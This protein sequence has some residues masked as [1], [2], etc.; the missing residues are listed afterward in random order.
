V[1]KLDDRT[2]ADMPNPS[3][4][5]RRS[6]DL[7][8]TV[9]LPRT[10]AL[11]LAFALLCAGAAAPAYAQAPACTPTHT[12]AQLQGD[13]TSSPFNF[14]LATTTGVVTARWT[15]SEPKGFFVQMAA[16]DG[17]AT[18]SDA[19]FVT[20]GLS[21]PPLEAMPGHEVCVEGMVFET[22]ATGDATGRTLTTLAANRVD[23]LGTGRPLPAPVTLTAALTTTG[24]GFERLEHLE[25]MRVQVTSL[26][27]VA[28]T[29]GVLDEVT[30]TVAST[31]VFFG[32]VAGV[33]R[34]FREAGVDVR[35]E[36]PWDAP[37]GIARFDGNA[38]RLRV[39]SRALGLGGLD[40]ATGATVS[41]VVGPLYYAD[42]AYTILPETTP[43]VTPATATAAS[44]AVPAARTTEATVATLNAYRL[45]DTVDSPDHFDDVLTPEALARRLA[46]LSLQ[47]R[48]VLRSPD[49]IGVQDVE[50][51]GVLQA[52]AARVNADA[53]AAAQPDPGYEAYLVEGSDLL[54]LDVGLLVKSSR[55]TVTSVVQE[56][57]DAT[58]V[59]P[60]TLSS[61][62]LND[63][64]PLVVRA[65]V[66]L[67]SGTLPV[68][69][70]V[71]HLRSMVG[72]ADPW[73]GYRVR[74]KRVEQAQ[75]L[76]GLVQDRQAA[77]ANEALVVLGDFNGHAFNDGFVDVFGTVKGTPAPAA[78]VV[79]PSTDVVNPDLTDALAGLTAGAR[80][81][82][83]DSGDATAL[84]HVL[85]NDTAADL[86]SRAAIAHANADFPEAL[87]NDASRAERAAASDSP[88]V[89]FEIQAA[90]PAPTPTPT[91]T[92]VPSGPVDISAKVK[93]K[94]WK[95]FYFWRH[96]GYTYALV[97]V[98]N[99]T[100]KSLTGPFHLA[101]AG[102]PAG[103]QV[104]NA[105]VT[106]DGKP[107]VP[108][109]WWHQLRPFRTMRAWIVL[110]GV[111][112]TVTPTV[113]VYSGKLA[114]N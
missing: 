67:S 98:T 48:T 2:E 103:A 12:I 38:E 76:A 63:R 64:P 109:F 45:F 28:P 82:G 58:F 89:Y 56:G 60:A 1:V 21:D 86:Q 11:T 39:D 26:S 32:V 3:S 84:H 37:A 96:R 114:L 108:V 79:A 33:S 112:S 85:V 77:V 90:E 95:S 8:S 66:A 47:I 97:D 74:A 15:T 52:L 5:V 36:L 80:Y 19:I 13:G 93:V 106:I 55:V 30:H 40:V 18:T 51:L 17:D 104:V 4:G 62:V 57:R 101:I 110:K 111:P 59:D 16:G 78:A 100:P 35:D 29:A 44:G 53:V 69:V 75:F 24:T 94:I 107:A 49:L 72:I 105:R 61:E 7:R 20:T 42:R 9:T 14:Y 50:N 22:A 92:P 81:T 25:G 113:K 34:P 54:G 31:G 83:T 46:K 27:V 91:P 87:L 102:L 41:N 43:G 99:V 68:N 23:L 71:T 10:G 6:F 70:I 73:D 88:V 65:T